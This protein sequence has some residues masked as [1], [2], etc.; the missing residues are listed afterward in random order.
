[1]SN[2]TEN[3]NIENIENTKKEAEVTIGV[4]GDGIFG[5]TVGK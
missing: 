4:S 3:G 5:A 1:M 2:E